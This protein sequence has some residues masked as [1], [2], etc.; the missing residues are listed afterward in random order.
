MK[1]LAAFLAALLLSCPALASAQTSTTKPTAKESLRD[2]AIKRCRQ[3][4]GTDC[5]SDRG[6]RE[7]L[8]EERPLTDAQRQAA[9]AG[10][11][12]REECART[13]GKAANC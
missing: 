9:A 4:R 12:H 2:R 8:R 3:N 11:R 13:K 10:R 6:L 7:W 5:D 1:L